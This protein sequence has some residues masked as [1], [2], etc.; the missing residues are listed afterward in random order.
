MSTMRSHRIYPAVYDVLSGSA[1]RC[2]RFISVSF[3][4]SFKRDVKLPLM[5]SCA[6][7]GVTSDITDRQICLIHPYT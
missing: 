7:C 3:I 1:C 6:E 2:G 4:K 5:L